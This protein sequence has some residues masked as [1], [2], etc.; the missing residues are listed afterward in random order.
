MIAATL[1]QQLNLR[2]ALA[3]WSDSAQQLAS[4]LAEEHRGVLGRRVGNKIEGQRIGNAQ[5]SGLND[6]T[7]TAASF[8]DVKKFADWQGEKAERAGRYD[9]KEYWDAIAKALEALE[10]EAWTVA[11]DAGLSVP[12]K[13]SKPQV[14]KKVLNE[15]YIM[16]AQEWVQ[17]FVAH[18]LMIAP[19]RED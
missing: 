15:I 8:E 17:H 3:K 13:D 4:T 16:L 12:P 6:I 2:R 10:K 1:E 14:L 18:S 7:Q 5:L 9:V 19:K 11:S